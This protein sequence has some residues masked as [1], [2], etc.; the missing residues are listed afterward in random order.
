MSEFENSYRYC[1]RAYLLGKPIPRT[2][3][4]TGDVFDGNVKAYNDFLKM[5]GVSR[6]STKYLPCPIRFSQNRNQ[7]PRNRNQSP[8]NRVF[9]SD[10]K[11]RNNLCRY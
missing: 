6:S 5:C 7:S 9:E 2:F 8:R 10:R 3:W 4:L 11:F 1:L